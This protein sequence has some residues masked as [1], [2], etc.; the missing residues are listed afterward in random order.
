MEREAIERLAMD[1]AAGQLNE[2][3]EA[4]L[5]TYLA[6]HPQA[7]KWAEDVRQ[8]YVKTE[9]AI[10]TKTD[11][12]G[13]GKVA[14]GITPVSQ[15]RWLSVARWAAMILFAALIGFSAGRWDRSNE[16]VRISLPVPGQATRRIETIAD[17]KEKYA[18]TF[19]GD[20]ALA[21][22]ESKSSR[23]YRTNRDIRLLDK[24]KQYIKEKHHGKS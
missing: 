11:H 4:L 12:T 9:A 1:S 21:L 17:L 14:R 18:G 22:M 3:A 23:Q 15:V 5:R 16:K 24:Y 10:K 7:N 19:W 2:D 6:E 13:V 20:K 8:I